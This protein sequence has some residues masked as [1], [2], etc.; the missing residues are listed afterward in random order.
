M[1]ILVISENFISKLH[2]F[3]ISNYSKH[4][5]FLFAFSIVNFINFEIEF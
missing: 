5:N 3:L 2:E 1:K 4:L